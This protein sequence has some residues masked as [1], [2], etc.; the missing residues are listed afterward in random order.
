V[1][2]MMFVLRPRELQSSAFLRLPPFNTAPHVL[3]AP[4]IMLFLLLLHN[5]N[6]ATVLNCN[7][8]IC[9]F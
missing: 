2:S 6:F 5:H 3:V 4:T 8:N 7:V 1:G 9:A